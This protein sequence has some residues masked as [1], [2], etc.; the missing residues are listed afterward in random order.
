MNMVPL[1][2][3]EQFDHLYKGFYTW[4]A[5]QYDPEY[6][7]F[8]YARSSKG[9][10]R[11]QPDIESTA[12]AINI[13]E[14][15]DL[16][17]T[18]PETMRH[19]LIVFFQSRQVPEGY[20]FDPHNNMR[21][22]DRMVGRAVN[23]SSNCLRRLGAKPI[24]PLPGTKGMATL[25]DYLKSV[26]GF[27]KWL[28][29]R[30]WDYAWMAGDNIQAAGIF[31]RQLPE[32]ERTVLLNLVWDY[33]ETHQ[34]P[35]TGMWGGGRPYIRLSGAFK[36]A[37][38]YDMFHKEIPRAD[39]I[40]QSVL[41][42]LRE[43]VS[44]DMCWTRNPMDLLR[45]LHYQLGSY[46]EKDLTEVIEITYRNLKQYLKP[47]GGFSRHPDRSLETPN[48]VQ[49]GKGLVEGDMNAGTQAVRIRSLCYSLAGVQA[50]TLAEYTKG[51][52]EK[53]ERG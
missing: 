24:Y 1:E 19:K 48:N 35:V 12:Q 5:G 31:I 46:P 30:P 45:V 26:D 16:L 39:R 33:L 34:D 47:D 51:F 14:A 49:L 18:M 4:L 28:D 2:K 8:Y 43:D 13:L 29:E 15:S 3:L 36:L 53:V 17:K 27:R 9:D 6:G 42:T 23:Y 40:Y 20:F 37:L 50:R 32:G 41:K 25:P 44:E 10:P 7:G 22:V 21:K 38:F 11:F 52:Y